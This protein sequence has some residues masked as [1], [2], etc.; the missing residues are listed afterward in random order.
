[1][2]YIDSLSHRHH[3]YI[4]VGN[5]KLSVYTVNDFVKHEDGNPITP[6]DLLIGGQNVYICFAMM[7][8]SVGF[9]RI[10]NGLIWHRVFLI[11][12]FSNI[13]D[14]ILH[15]GHYTSAA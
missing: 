1:M 15:H 2:S 6:K 11:H 7:I 13:V 10:K 9:S 12:I 8:S 4:M 14:M 3:G 5:Q